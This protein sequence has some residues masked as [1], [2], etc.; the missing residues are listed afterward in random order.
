[1]SQS[2]R[3][4]RKISARILATVVV[5]ILLF[6]FWNQYLLLKKTDVNFSSVFF[7][8]TE[9]FFKILFVGTVVVTLFSLFKPRI[10]A[11]SVFLFLVT[12]NVVR[13]FLHI[14]LHGAFSL[15]YP[16]FVHYG[17]VLIAVFLFLYSKRRSFPADK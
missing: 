11:I 8:D 15:S 17:F 14:H 9:L 4:I 6:D 1:M 7:G 12:L 2:R 5:G 16:D 3:T 13:Y 10:G